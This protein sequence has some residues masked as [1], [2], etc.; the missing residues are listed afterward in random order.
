[1][2][3]NNDRDVLQTALAAGA[4]AATKRMR[5]AGRRSWDADDA[6]LACDVAGEVLRKLGYSKHPVCVVADIR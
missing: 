3:L 5:R 1:V 6:R 4:D 2:K